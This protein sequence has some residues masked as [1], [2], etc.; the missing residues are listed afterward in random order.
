MDK[1]KK[2]ENGTYY[3]HVYLGRNQVTGKDVTVTRHGIPSRAEAKALLLRLTNEYE[4]GTLSGRPIRF[5]DVSEKWLKHYRETVR[6]STYHK[7]EEALRLHVIPAFGGLLLDQISPL[8]AQD[9]ADTLAVKLR[10]YKKVYSLPRRVFDYAI[11]IGVYSDVNPF[12]R[13]FLPKEQGKKEQEVE[14]L[15]AEEMKR[16]LEVLEESPKWHLYFRLLCYTGMRKGE[17]LA[18]KWQDVDFKNASLSVS[19]TIT[20]GDGNHEYLSERPKTAAGTRVVTLD[21]GTLDELYHYFTSPLL[22]MKG[23]IFTNTEGSWLNLS[24]PGKVLNRACR[25]AGLPPIRVH[26]LRHSHCAMLFEAGWSI[27]SVQER[28]GHSDIK[29]TMDVYAHVTK[30]THAEE[31]NKLEKL[32][33]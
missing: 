30:K 8:M 11:K 24:R 15:E 31:M 3:F 5:K 21:R 27:K 33:G 17:A 12:E 28:L 7:T 26:V 9:F 20:V 13:V 23:F 14:Y 16:L 22:S 19:K 25:R 2:A 6:E 29:T 32:L 10:H 4:S 18:L 1:I